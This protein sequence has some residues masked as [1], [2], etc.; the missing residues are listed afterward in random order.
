ML[1]LSGSFF[2]PASMGTDQATGIRRLGQARRKPGVACPLFSFFYKIHYRHKI[3][4][5]KYNFRRVWQTYLMRL[6]PDGLFFVP[7]GTARISPTFTA[8]KLELGSL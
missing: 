6:G 2:P 7:A 4:T 3:D 8:L 1:R 5:Y